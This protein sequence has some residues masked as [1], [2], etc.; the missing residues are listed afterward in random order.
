[1]EL[2]ETL[3]NWFNSGGLPLP[4]LPP[5]LAGRLEEEGELLF[6][7]PPEPGGW[8]PPPALGPERAGFALLGLP[9]DEPAAAGAPPLE[10]AEGFLRLGLLGQGLQ[11]WRFHYLLRRPGF[12]FALELPYGGAFSDPELEKIELN[13]GFDLARLCLLAAKEDQGRGWYVLFSEDICRF[14]R[15][16]PEGELLNEGEDLDA[17]LSLLEKHGGAAQGQEWIPV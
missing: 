2:P 17:L 9:E 4:P 1:M 7:S 11:S 12:G 15:L 16:S 10:P 14:R 6:S 3:L 5:D 8:P 13:R